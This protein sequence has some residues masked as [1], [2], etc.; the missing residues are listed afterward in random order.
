MA[1]TKTDMVKSIVN[2][3]TVNEIKGVYFEVS[4]C[5]LGGNNTI[6]AEPMGYKGTLLDGMQ[7]IF[8][9]GIYEVS[10]FMAG[11]KQNELHVYLKTK[12]LKLAMNSILKGNKKRTI[13][14][15]WD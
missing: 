15:K 1:I 4:D 12:S 6:I 11:K 14:E 5:S 2:I 8:E 9:N 7:I 3:L 13:I 10:Q